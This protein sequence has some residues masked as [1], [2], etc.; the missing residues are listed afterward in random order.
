M[1]FLPPYVASS[2][3]APDSGRCA[4]SR[5]SVALRGGR[6]RPPL[7]RRAFIDRHGY[8]RRRRRHRSPK[9]ERLRI[10]PQ[11]TSV[12][13]SLN[14]SRQE[15]TLL[16]LVAPPLPFFCT[17]KV[18]SKPGIESARVGSQQSR[19]PGS[20]RRS[21]EIL[22]L[23]SFFARPLFSLSLYFISNQLDPH[24]LVISL[25]QVDGGSNPR[26]DANR[27]GLRQS[28]RGL[29]RSV[30]RQPTEGQTVSQTGCAQA[31]TF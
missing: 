28:A 30:S 1:N 14:V 31:S 16:G 12:Q 9:P 23:V 20:R 27:C 10:A 25:L 8:E 5:I 3:E 7:R 6:R 24:L 18:S 26:N 13:F 21:P 19:L 22:L 29:S 4:S 11:N 15:R 2:R 17:W